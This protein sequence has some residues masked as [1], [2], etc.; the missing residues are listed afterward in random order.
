MEHNTI[1][2]SNGKKVKLVG[3]GIFLA[4]LL[5]STIGY[6]EI[7]SDP[8]TKAFA[9]L[10]FIEGSF[11]MGI[12]LVIVWIGHRIHKKASHKSSEIHEN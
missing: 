10:V 2:T 1:R 8:S 4:A 9:F 11:F 5:Y 12:G 6:F 3:W 7:V